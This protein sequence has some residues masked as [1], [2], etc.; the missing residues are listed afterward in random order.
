MEGRGRE[1]IGEG[2]VR[3]GSMTEEQVR[4]VLQVQREQKEYD[5]L[6]GEIAVELELVDPETIDR[7]LN[8]EA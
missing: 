5:K 4:K 6:F 7:Y 1:K 8:G 2:L 3:I